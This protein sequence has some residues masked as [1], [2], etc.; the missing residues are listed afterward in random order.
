MKAAPKG[1]FINFYAF[2]MGD[3]KIKTWAPL[4]LKAQHEKKEGELQT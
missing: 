4:N 3:A 2:G 1:W